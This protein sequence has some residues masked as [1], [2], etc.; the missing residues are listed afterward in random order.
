[1]TL[2]KAL[3]VW[4]ILGFGGLALA[5]TPV[6]VTPLAAA[7]A[8][9]DKTLGQ[10]IANTLMQQIVDY[11]GQTAHDMDV[12][13]EVIQQDSLL[14]TQANDLA[15]MMAFLYKTQNPLNPYYGKPAARDRAIAMTD[16]IVKANPQIEWPFY[17][18]IQAYEF[19][20]N[21][22]S[23][24]KAADW[25]AHAALYVRE[26][27]ARPF[28]Y[29]SPNHEAWN[30]MAIYRAGQVFG[31]LQWRTTG[32]RLMHN[33]MK[34]QTPLG[35]FDEGYPGNG[36][37][38]K[39][40]SI[41]LAAM[42]LYVDFSGDRQ[43]EADAKKLFDFMVRYSYPDGS[44]IAA[45]DGRQDYSFGYFGTIPY[46]FAR[47]PE[48]KALDLR[49]YE[50]RKKWG[51]LDVHSPHYSFS[52]WYAAFGGLMLVDEYQSW[53]KH[54]DAP[55]AP[56]PQDANGYQATNRG[57][58]FDGGVVRQDGWMVALSGIGS[59][60]TKYIHSIYNLE[61]QSR[62]GIWNKRTGLIIGG[63]SSMMGAAM[64]LANF[65]LIT[66][67]KGV[68]GDFGV[69]SGGEEA[70]RQATYFPTSFETSFTQ[71]QQKLDIG[72]G[73]GDFQVTVLPQSA[74]QLELGYQY[75]TLMAKQAYIQLPVILFDNSKVAVDGRNYDGK[76]AMAVT[77]EITIENPTT[78]TTVTI[79][80][81]KNG[82]ARLNPAVD[83]MRWYIDD[84]VQNRY[85]PYYRIA[86]LSL[87]L[88]PAQGHGKFLIE[89][90]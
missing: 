30:A 87:S 54:M 53:V 36:P 31:E 66:G 33:L 8:P 85:T 55:V 44:P 64:P 62:I 80:I 77:H 16:R 29:T 39:Y 57:C 76:T 74:S 60:V 50:T 73:H 23:P 28:G 4:L 46:G 18:L 48:G 63:G 1:M 26:R 42:L 51:V 27:G 83:P 88:D 15:A 78:H 43:V 61:K 59:N 37:S 58:T 65:E 38:M 68:S 5:A 52:N 10:A 34:L 47:W 86:L 25:R 9:A 90:K 56:L 35:Y 19:L 22:V 41:Q 11:A 49:I 3:L 2:R 67:Y 70:D 14:A 81:P 79:T 17:N 40:N 21:D 12:N 84:H 45:F 72:F 24:A 6:T 7:A 82:N 13:R 32:T 89:V 71:Q 20:K 75:D 69:L